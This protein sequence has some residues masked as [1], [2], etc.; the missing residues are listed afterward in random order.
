MEKIHAA[1][2]STHSFA[3]CSKIKVSQAM[4]RP[5]EPVAALGFFVSVD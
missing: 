1:F 5:E 2:K 3:A 4:R